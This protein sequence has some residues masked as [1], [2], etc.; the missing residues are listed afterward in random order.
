MI[1]THLTGVSSPLARRGGRRGVGHHKA[2]APCIQRGGEGARDRGLRW[3]EA[4]RRRAQI[5][6]AGRPLPD[7]PESRCAPRLPGEP[8]RPMRWVIIIEIWYNRRVTRNHCLSLVWQSSDY[9]NQAERRR[10]G[11]PCRVRRR[12]KVFYRFA[13]P[14]GYH[15]FSSILWRFIPSTLKS[16]KTQ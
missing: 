5:G 8:L 2:P 15:S 7:A 11:R 4:A 9:I 6:H 10:L 16:K 13:C 3:G 12:G 1:I 14:C